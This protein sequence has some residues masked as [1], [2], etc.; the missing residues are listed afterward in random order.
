[1]NKPD[2]IK[3]YL[4]FTAMEDPRSS[5]IYTGDVVFEVNK[6]ISDGIYKGISYLKYLIKQKLGSNFEHKSDV[7][8]PICFGSILVMPIDVPE[9]FVIRQINR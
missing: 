6:E 5:E 8:A 2:K 4:T 9:Y 3:I 1:M 7:E